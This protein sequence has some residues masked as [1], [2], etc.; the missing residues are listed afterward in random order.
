MAVWLLYLECVGL[1]AVT[2]YLIYRDLTADSLAVGVAISLTVMA[3]LA[4]VV[5]FFLARSLGRRQKGA[6]GPAIVVQLF[7]I[8]SGGF[9]VQVGPLWL[10][11]IL[12]VTGAVTGVLIVVP[13]STRALGVD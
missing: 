7:V 5:V 12:L 10:G 9:Q 8:A 1:A 4:A 6:R 13:P 3:A 2:A 11:L